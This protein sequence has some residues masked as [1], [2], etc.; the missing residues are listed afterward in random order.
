MRIRWNLF[1]S[2]SQGNEDVIIDQLLG[3]KYKGF[4]VDI[5]A[6]NP[7]RFSNTKRFYLKGWRG[8]NIEP[9]PIRIKKFQKERPEDI[10]LNVGI[11]RQNGVLDFFKFDPSTLST[12]SKKT[13]NSYKK[14]GHKL[15]ETMKIRVYRLEYILSKN[16]R[17]K[18]ID[19]FSIDTEGFDF[20][21]LKSNNWKKFKP[22]VICIENNSTKVRE[23][24]SKIGYKKVAQTHVN[25]IYKLY[26]KHEFQ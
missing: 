6:Y 25:G 19:F 3:N 12:F 17:G 24:L 14:Q 18:E 20:E 1:K 11:A 7:T 2:F 5:G 8:I 16:F 10:N 26:N 21:V 13:A 23:F 15:V 9:D 22:K 4:Y